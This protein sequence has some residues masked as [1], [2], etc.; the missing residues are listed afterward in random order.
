M[1]ITRDHVYNTFERIR[2]H[3]NNGKFVISAKAYNYNAQIVR[4]ATW[5]IFKITQRFG[6][7]V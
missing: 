7:N 2:L 3:G 1:K 5:I 4:D 6:A